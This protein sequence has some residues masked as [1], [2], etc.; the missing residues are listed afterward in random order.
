MENIILISIA[1]DKLKDIIKEAVQ[2]EFKRK[3]EKEVMNFKETC[4]FLGISSSALNKW[5]AA[6]KIPYNK[7]GKRL[8][9][10]KAELLAALK[11]SNYRKLREL[12]YGRL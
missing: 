4:E 8:F 7:M 9:F 12:G 6:N 5:K 2:D 11:E 3:R 1:E 10:K